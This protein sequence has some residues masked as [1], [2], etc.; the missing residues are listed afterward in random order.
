MDIRRVFYL[1]GSLLRQVAQRGGCVRERTRGVRRRR[2]PGPAGGASAVG[3]AGE[4]PFPFRMVVVVVGRWVLVRCFR[5]SAGKRP[6][7]G[8][9]TPRPN[10]PT[11]PPSSPPRH[12]TPGTGP[13][14][15][16]PPNPTTERKNAAAKRDN[17]TWRQISRKSLSPSS[18][19][20]QTTVPMLNTFIP[21]TDTA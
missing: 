9:L 7:S 20:L 3:R 6:K 11:S 15:R 10:Q 17:P 21:V 16:S 4:R 5:A 14:H 13:T 8:A 2:L 18:S 12:P 1:R 19:P